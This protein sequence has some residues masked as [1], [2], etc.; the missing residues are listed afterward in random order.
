MA[1][2]NS[3]KVATTDGCSW[4]SSGPMESSEP[5]LVLLVAC[6]QDLEVGLRLLDTPTLLFGQLEKLLEV[7]VWVPRACHHLT[8]YATGYVSYTLVRY[9]KGMASRTSSGAGTSAAEFR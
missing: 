9:P 5:L 2:F 8:R 3:Y 7:F 1:P 4:R 6:A